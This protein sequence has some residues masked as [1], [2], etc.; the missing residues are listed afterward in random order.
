MQECLRTL[1]LKHLQTRAHH[2]LANGGIEPMHRTLKK[3]VELLVSTAP[4]AL[5]EAIGRFVIYW[6]AERYHDTLKNAPPADVHH[7]RRED[8][9]ARRRSLQMR[10]LVARREHCR[11]RVRTQSSESV[12]SAV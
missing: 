7:G 1:G 6:N 12:P 4:D 3:E 10:T 8:T 9:L 5:R 2:P 11:A